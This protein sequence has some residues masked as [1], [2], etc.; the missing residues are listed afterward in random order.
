LRPFSSRHASRH[1]VWFGVILSLAIA[2][3]LAL[4]ASDVRGAEVEQE[5][6]SQREA[7]E[8]TRAERERI[9]KELEEHRKALT[10]LERRADRLDEERQA[11]ERRREELRL[12]EAEIE[13]G[14]A[15]RKAELRE[16]LQAAYPLTRGGAL[17]ALLAEGDALQAQRDLHYLRAL[18]E[19]IQ[20]ARRALVQQ[21]TALEENRRE[22]GE[23]DAQ[24]K[25]NRETIE[26]GQRQLAENLDRQETLLA[27]LGE[28][29]DR[30]QTELKSL[31]ER[32]ERLEREVRAAARA[33]EREKRDPEPAEDA[34]P[35]G[36][37]IAGIPIEGRI[38]RNYGESMPT[39]R[40]RQEGVTFR[41]DGDLPVRAIEEGSV[42]YA[43]TLKGW[44]RL[45]MLR[46]PGDYLSLYAHC[47]SLEVAKGDRVATGTTLCRSGTVDAQQ[48]GLYVEVR[49]RNRPVDPSRWDAWRRTVDG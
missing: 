26:A 19:P 37:V 6:D 18:I 22:I 20:R 40:L 11:L 34:P 16:R 12:R 48:T 31:L 41:A 7:I 33:R 46:H 35:A 47:R 28:T 29:L 5:I 17:Q 36:R 4:A 39:G 38:W 21:Q 30:Q 24:L 2:G 3:P 9:R 44:G 15:E 45:V 1:P 14:L 43:G 23:T 27:G 8:S 42:V 49:H 13:R 32:K 10:E 25:R